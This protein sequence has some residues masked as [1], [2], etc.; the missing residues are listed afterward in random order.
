VVEELRP[1]NVVTN[2]GTAMQIVVQKRSAPSAWT[3]QKEV[4][5][6]RP[7]TTV[8]EENG[9]KAKAEVTMSEAELA[10]EALEGK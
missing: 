9:R 7:A 5:V 10:D 6:D 4:V 2:D 8:L 1:E 3:R